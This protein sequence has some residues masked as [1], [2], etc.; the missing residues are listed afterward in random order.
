MS[1]IPASVCLK[2]AVSSSQK[3]LTRLARPCGSYWGGGGANDK[4]CL[5]FVGVVS[6]AWMEDVPTGAVW[7]SRV[8]EAVS[9]AVFSEQGGRRLPA[10]LTGAGP[11]GTSACANRGTRLPLRWQ[12]DGLTPG[13]ARAGSPCCPFRMNEAH[14]DGTFFSVLV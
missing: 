4:S 10:V 7:V 5:L 3:L 9:P 13:H 1:V 12:A 8:M 6:V 11:L 2:N 14:P